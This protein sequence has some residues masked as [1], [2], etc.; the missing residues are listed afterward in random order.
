MVMPM[1]S[2]P[3]AFLQPRGAHG[4]GEGGE[5]GRGGSGGS[6]GGGGEGSDGSTGRG[7]PVEGSTGSKG[8]TASSKSKGGGHP[9]KLGKNSPFKGR[10]AGG[11]TRDEIVG[12]SRYGS[13]W[14]YGGTGT[15]VDQRPLPFI[16]WPIAIHHG[17]Y[18]GDIYYRESQRPG[19]NT[20]TM[21]IPSPDNATVIYRVTGDYMSVSAIFDA[22]ELNCLPGNGTYSIATFGGFNNDSDTV[23]PKPE[24]VVQWY[25]ASSFALSLDGYNNSAALQSRMPANSTDNSTLIPLSEDTPLPPYINSTFLTCLNQTIAQNLPLIN[26][27]HH[28]LSA[29]AE[30]G[31]IFVGS[32][33]GFVALILLCSTTNGGRVLRKSQDQPRQH[34]RPNRNRRDLEL[35]HLS[36]EVA[37]S[38]RDVSKTDKHVPRNPLG[39][40]LL[41]P[42]LHEQTFRDAWPRPPP[43]QYIR[44]A[45]EHLE[46]HGLDPSQGSV[47]PDVSFTLPPLWGD[48]I[49]EHFHF[50][51]STIYQPWITIAEDFATEKLLPKPEHW[52]LQPGWTKYHYREDGSSYS[53][54]VP[55]PMHDGEVE[56]MLVFDVETMPEY[57]PYPVMACAATQNGWYAWISPWLLGESKDPQHLITFG[58]PGE[59][60]IIVGHNV[61][62]DRARIAEEYRLEGTKTRFVDTMSLHVAVKGISSHQRP[63][64]N[65]HRKAK[66][67]AREQRE[68]AMDT[69]LQ[70]LRD[71]KE[72]E[73]KAKGEERERL[74]Q[75]IAGFEESLP[76]LNRAMQ[77]DLPDEA[78][79]GNSDEVETKRWEDL[80]SANSL[81][82]VASLYCGIKVEKEIRSDFMTHSREE[83]LEG[84]QD[85]LNYCANDVDVTHAV[86][87]KVLPAFR[88]RCPHPVSFAG[89]LTMGSSFLPVNQEW[90]RYLENAERT[91]KEL[92]DGVKS[93]LVELAEQ[94]RGM[95]ETEAWKESPWLSQLD[96]T[97]K[98]VGASRGNGAVAS[99]SQTMRSTELDTPN[100]PE[101]DTLP[102]WYKAIIED[103][104]ISKKVLNLTMPYLLRLQLDGRP[105]RYS[106]TRGW[107][108]RHP[109]GEIQLPAKR[110]KV[111]AFIG[112]TNGLPLF[113]NGRVTSDREG[114]AELA[115][116]LAKGYG[117]P[118]YLRQVLTIAKEALAAGP[119]T[120]PRS[121]DDEDADPWELLDWT[122]NGPRSTRDS[123][124]SK[125]KPKADKVVYWPKWYW[126]L[127]R[128]R[129]G[130]PPGSL[131]L[132]VSKRISPLLLQ[133]SW[134]GW[135]LFHSREH[136]WAF[137]VPRSVAYKPA[138]TSTPLYFAHQ[139]DAKLGDMACEFVFYKMPHKDGEEANVG[140][141]LGKTF[142]KYAQDGTMTSPSDAAKDALDMNGQCSYWISARDR[143][144]NQIVVWQDAKREL[145]FPTSGE[146]EKWGVILPQMVTMGTVTRRAMERTW[147]TASNAKKNRVGSELKAMVR[148]PPG[149]AIVGADVDSEELWIASVLGDAQFGMH[150][151]TALGWMTLEGT[152]AAGT[153][154]HSKTASILGIS[155]DQAKVFNYSRIYGAGMRHAVQLLLQNSAG[156]SVEKAQE[157]ATELYART[158][159]KNTH[160]KDLFG[161]KFWYGGT[162]SVVFN[163]LEAVALADVPQTPALGCGVTDALTKAYLTEGFGTDYMTSRINWVVQSSGVDY[164][165]M[166][167]VA[168]EHLMRDFNIRARYLIS[169]HDELRYLVKEED[170]YRAALALQIAH[171]W[172]RTM[173]AYRLGLDDLPQGVA[174]FS[175]VDVDKVLRKEVDMPCV[176][177]S[178]PNPIPPGESLS[179][180]DVL[181]KTDGGSL[182][183][184]GPMPS[185]EEWADENRDLT[186]RMI[187]NA[188]NYVPPNT[189]QHRAES[190]YFLRAQTTSE[191]AE[192]RMLAR[193]AQRRADPTKSSSTGKRKASQTRRSAGDKKVL[194]VVNVLEVPELVDLTER[195]LAWQ[196][197]HRV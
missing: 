102:A 106:T 164:L 114:Y 111:S 52:E 159:G 120:K 83:I 41:S 9:H 158:K 103:G 132:T 75:L 12:T 88:E 125:E 43:K 129:K 67:K 13:G 182:Y 55:Y 54:A 57:S 116:A 155:R 186:V 188:T 185:P 180:V 160:R 192:V 112:P 145:G 148:A 175:A 24:Q 174:F 193:Q 143:I 189:M 161:R 2:S 187:L 3:K 197:E 123:K 39:V 154:L 84:V 61:S 20:S 110:R 21:A 69:V 181:K 50:I 51:G 100:I 97:P 142:M 172:T 141:P 105:L 151:A 139:A 119:P 99:T 31:I 135:P 107:Y 153:D 91:Y 56:R 73:L 93:R 16:F 147:L 85:Y 36:N 10:L 89:I 184:G 131:D 96:W 68:E 196:G 126:D 87:S 47:L 134:Q 38:V 92:D 104:P 108:C 60:R 162:E 64:W 163:K 19:G 25:R 72:A 124:K 32:L 27:K 190:A 149:Y 74:R 169:V 170:K 58:E 117:S 44:I 121:A 23:F 191:L 179:I 7:M 115:H 40:Q 82:D 144:L 167:I 22:L 146:D 71:A 49:D 46:A 63:A 94:A 86:Y 37:E 95:A 118:I 29:G 137:R 157:L 150:G 48:N 90:E 70:M 98:K 176:T 156:M 113:D 173:F 80:T 166:L 168:M 59:E 165:H 11:G 127:T 65:K 194:S 133:L 79:S 122:A 53:E 17:Y 8:V 15:F 81:A 30:T 45:R 109:D 138:R 76:A 195:Y 5:G 171:L 66:D 183:P 6:G 101:S 77:E 18:G 4:G 35:E 34:D 33:V 78:D 14:P 128:P 28:H 152:K 136:G 42:S 140:N 178:Q 62:Y 130:H 177:P 1:I 26:P